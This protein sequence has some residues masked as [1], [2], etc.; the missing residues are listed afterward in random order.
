MTV[1]SEVF[2]PER[3][4]RALAALPPVRR[5]WVAYSGGPDSH[6]LLH[7]MTALRSGPGGLD[8][9]AV[10]VHH[11]LQPQA[12]AW[13]EHCRR[14]CTGLAVDLRVLEVD[15]RARSGESPEAAARRARYGVLAGL[16][17]ARELILV[18]HHRDDQAETVLLQLLRGAG[19]RG[20]A[21]MPA[22]S[23][24]GRGWLGR[25]LLGVSRA[26]LHAYAASRELDVVSDASNLDER[27]ARNFLRAQVVPRLRSRWPGV[28]GTLARIAAQQ[29]EV[30]E[31]L[32]DLAVMDLQTL[33]G[34]RPGTLDCTGL[35]AL[36]EARRRN[37]LRGWLRQLDL[38]VPSAAQMARLLT[39]VIDARP[40]AQPALR[41]AGAEVRRHRDLL[42]AT[43][44]LPAQDPELVLNWDVE[45]PLELATGTL[46]ARDARGRGVA[47]ARCTAEGLE[48]RFRRGGE[49]CRPA[50][51]GHT[52]AVKKLLQELAVPP[53]ERD[54]I[55]LVYID[56]CLAAVGDLCVCEPFGAAPGEPG[57]VLRWY[58]KGRHPPSPS[59]RWRAG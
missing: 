10:H 57:K 59:F 48:V 29:A 54:R 46:E 17:S 25:P 14:I 44:P 37:A 52:H 43:P 38:A 35:R 4:R 18:A 9:G 21:G 11:G 22:V 45:R 5:Y 1:T 31:L 28:S 33:H 24:L 49:R 47:A 56:G 36:P 19:A 2:S 42:Y 26:A 6:A 20:L 55:P 7:A 51:R 53:W 8:L 23:R 30:A 3:L 50:G 34:P 13:V 40:D 39:D 41:W 27:H 15:A 58:P 16:V 32:D 12:D